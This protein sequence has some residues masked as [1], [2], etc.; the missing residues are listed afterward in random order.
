MFLEAAFFDGINIAQTGRKQNIISDSRY[1]FERNIDIKSVKKALDFAANLILDICGGEISKV[2]EVGSDNYKESIIEVRISKINK[3][4]N[5]NFNIDDVIK[6]LS[7]LKFTIK[8]SNQDK[9]IVKAPSFRSDIAI[10]EDLIEE[11]IRIHGY[12]NIES[13]AIDFEQYNKIDLVDKPALK[14][15]LLEKYFLYHPKS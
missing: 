9:I 14:M 8:E 6:I 11:F 4:L 1:R 7:D 10:E 3:V 13:Q 2:I 5:G 15:L 12:N